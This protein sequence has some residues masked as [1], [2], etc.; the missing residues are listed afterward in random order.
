[1][2]KTKT[3]E[4]MEKEFLKKYLRL[5]ILMDTHSKTKS[6]I[7]EKFDYYEVSYKQTVKEKIEEVKDDQS[8]EH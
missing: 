7:Q 5:L 6:E 1:M 8:S 3:I 4:L 2:E